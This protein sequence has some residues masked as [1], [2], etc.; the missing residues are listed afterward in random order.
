MTGSATV[1]TIFWR[2]I[3]QNEV[4]ITASGEV[5]WGIKKLNLALALDNTGSMANDMQGLR[6]AASDLASDL[7]SLDGD[8]VRVALV[9]FVAQPVLVAG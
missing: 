7:M 5:V 1:D 8:T 2:V 4:N 3:G 9:P 6:D